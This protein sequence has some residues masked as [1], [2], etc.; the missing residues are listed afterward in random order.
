MK[1]INIRTRGWTD[2]VDITTQVQKE[3]EKEKIGN[4]LAH[5]FVIGS[6]ASLTTI[7][8][9]E[10]LFADLKEILE[11]IA[12]YKKNWQHHKTW[13]DDNG[14]AHLRA[15]LFGPSLTIPIINSKLFLGTWQRI[16]LID[17]DTHPREREIIVSLIKT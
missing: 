11:K 17:F 2:I 16:V 5:L 3:L 13:S 1:V 12:P 4:G 14:A 6:T 10:N 8:D 7:E 9:D 15:S